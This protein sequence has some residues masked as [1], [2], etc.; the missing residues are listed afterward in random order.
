MM[1]HDDSTE[2]DLIV[3]GGGPGGSSA[4]TFVAMQGHRVLLLEKQKT[5]IYK[6]GESLLPATIHGICPMLGV[7]DALKRENFIRKT[8]GTFI[9]GKSRDP[10][11]FLFSESA[12]FAGPTSTAYQVERMKFD[13]ILLENARE[14]GVD[15]REQHAANE[16]LIE[17]NR[18][19]GVRY[20]DA[21]GVR[22]TSR[23]HYVIDACGHQSSLHRYAGERVYSKLFENISLFGYYNGGKR[24]PSPAQGNQFSATFK[25]GWFWY[26]PLRD[27]L[28]SVGVVFGRDQ[29]ARLSQGY[30]QAFDEFIEECPPIKSM[31]SDAT[32]VT[33]GP[34]GE[35]RVCKDFSYCTT[36]FW[37]NGL[38]LVGDTA[39][40]VDPLFSSGVHLA[41]Y[42]GLLAARSIN[43]RLSGQLTD[44]ICFMEYEA[45]YRREYLHFYD[46][47]LGFYDV[48]QDVDSEFWSTRK[49]A[50]SPEST[51][52]KF[53]S[54]IAGA[55][56]G[57]GACQDPEQFLKHRANLGPAL[58]PEA[59]GSK[60]PNELGRNERR[61]FLG[62]L[63]GELAQLQLQ[64]V[65]MDK[66]PV[67]TP[68]FPGG[69]VPSRDG[70]HWK[71]QDRLVS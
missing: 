26:I 47:L 40:F 21:S 63:F 42:S 36:R 22:R 7:S 38:I 2:V 24:L 25:H 39:C 51:N 11:E 56:G 14:K 10:W 53:I 50:N 30:A 34:Y 65:F 46:F 71:Q 8:G 29:A 3:I 1:D 69:L 27:D 31:I 33:D 54:V 6:V 43:T 16:L 48:H 44:D 61:A 17:G 13:Q 32:R 62:R 20:T 37:R 59:A 15:V 28:T 41:T 68:L 60:A 23:S 70:F 45:R 58:F 4:A 52:H 35:L 19:T 55:A 5:P 67:E 18:V 9:W 12:K 64:A 66:R 49:T 57:A